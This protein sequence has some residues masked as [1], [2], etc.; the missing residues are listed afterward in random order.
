MGAE[1]KTA[2]KANI[3]FRRCGGFV[4]IAFPWLISAA[5]LI[6][7]L[8]GVD[9]QLLAV[10]FQNYPLAWS[11][12]VIF[13]AQVGY[14]VSAWRF[15]GLAGG[16]AAYGTVLKGIIIGFGYNNILP[17][18]AGEILK[19]LYLAKASGVPAAGIGAIVFWERVFDVLLLLS[20]SLCLFAFGFQP[21]PVYVPL[22]MLCVGIL[23]F[24]WAKRYSHF[25]HG[26]YQKIPSKRISGIL[27][28]LHVDAV[29]SVSWRWLF[30]GLWKTTV[31]WL[32]Y[33]STYVAG[34]LLVASLNI[35]LWQAAIAFIAASIA[36]AIP[37]SPGG[38]GMLEGAVVFSLS[39]FDIP[40]ESSLAIALFLHAAYFLPV[41][42]LAIFIFGSSLKKRKL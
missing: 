24:L 42:L 36:L 35:Q 33:M 39:W 15:Q 30:R 18:K 6:Y 27:G 32:V 19:I 28:R 20:L 3:Y 23:C 4:K 7:S 31:L 38:I 25:F 2:K 22:G 40:R 8:W 29:D 17:A 10:S 16:K 34:F 37:S 14:A 12:L 26:W 1:N 41:T 11:C 13:A 21:V 9:F 5:L